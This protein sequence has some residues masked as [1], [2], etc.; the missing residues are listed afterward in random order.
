MSSDERYFPNP[1]PDQYNQNDLVVDKKYWLNFIR[2]T[3]AMCMKKMK[4]VAKEKYC[5][6]A[7]YTGIFFCNIPW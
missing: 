3:S 6:G 5:D 1:Y 2:E 7:L 4:P